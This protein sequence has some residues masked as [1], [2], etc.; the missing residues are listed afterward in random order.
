MTNWQE[1][2]K[3]KIAEIVTDTYIICFLLVLVPVMQYFNL[4][5]DASV[6][7]LFVLGLLLCI[8]LTLAIIYAKNIAASKSDFGVSYQ[9]LDV[10]LIILFLGIIVFIIHK[11]SATYLE[12]LFVVPVLIATIGFPRRTGAVLTGFIAVTVLIVNFLLP[13]ES[14]TKITLMDLVVGGTIVLVGWLL[15]ELIAIE[16]DG[17]SRLLGTTDLDDLTALYNHRYFQEYL[18]RH[19]QTAITKSKPLSL[20][21]F[22]IDYFKFYNEIHGHAHGDD[23]LKEIGRVL[24][25]RVKLPGIAARIGG[26][27]FAVILPDTTSE[28][29]M[30]AAYEIY[31]EIESIPAHGFQNLPGAKL[32]VSIGVAAYPQHGRSAE[33]LLRSVDYALYKAKNTSTDKVELYFNVFDSLRSEVPVSSDDP[34]TY[35]KVI[36][37]VINSKDRY[38]F[39]HSERVLGYATKMAEYLQLPEREKE[40]LYY[41]AYLHDIGKVNIDSELLN[42]SGTLS[43]EEWSVFKNHSVWGRDIILPFMSDVTV[44][45]AILH[46]HENYDGTGYPHGIS[47]D[48]IPFLARVLRVLDSFDAMTTDRPYKKAKTVRKA[49]EE[50]LACAGS[51]YDPVVAEKFVAM[52]QAEPGMGGKEHR[53]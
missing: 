48:E 46:H 10:L 50:I 6:A 42:K 12:I 23:V 17:R 14:Y 53:P 47:G 25:L 29:A 28:E 34:F 22:D 5:P 19:M 44:G 15:G 33:D 38:T 49:L 20:I 40:I 36:I 21:V 13:N 1:A 11:T 2:R 30:T 3:K 27:E 4:Q 39:G 7:M 32:H 9:I 45:L 24:S 26:D 37:S 16:Q 35:A 43:E 41:A 8:V 52:M 18:R 31:Q 51:L